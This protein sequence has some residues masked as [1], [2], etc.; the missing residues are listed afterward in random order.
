MRAL[1]LFFVLSIAVNQA[2]SNEMHNHFSI[3]DTALLNSGA[4]FIEMHQIEVS[5]KTW[6][7]KTVNW[8]NKNVGERKKLVAAV[9]AFPVFG[10]VGLHRIYMGTKP[11]VPVVYIATIGGCFGIIPFIDFCTIIFSD[12]ETFESFQNNPKVLMWVN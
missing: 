8:I 3:G 11:Y 1:V 12:S 2:V 7:I 9:L 6:K 5:E 10:V 4:D